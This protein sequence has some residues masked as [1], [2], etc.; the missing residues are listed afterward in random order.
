MKTAVV[1]P[2]RARGNG[3][4]REANLARV[5]EH[6]AGYDCEVLVT[7][8]GRSGDEQ[9]NRS[10]AYNRASVRG[11]E[12]ASN[13]DVF[14][15]SE[16]DIIIS[17]EQ[18]DRAVALAADSPGMVVPF[19]WF[20]ALTREDSASVRAHEVDPSDCIRRATTVKGHRGS[21]GAVNVVSRH[22][23]D[24]VEGYDESFEGAWYDDDA[25]K[26]AFEVCAGPTRWVEGS[27]YHLYHLSGGRGG[28]LTNEDRAATA[29]NRQRYRLYQQARTPEQIRALTAG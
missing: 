10:A 1:I 3:A 21:I 8:D 26:I 24:L 20:M 17:Y 5:T 9:F 6:W 11:L 15:F 29:R 7:S 22:T 14:V 13:A 27:A 18:V 23:L 25:M 12:S 28:H 16:S 19:S 4:L 2:F